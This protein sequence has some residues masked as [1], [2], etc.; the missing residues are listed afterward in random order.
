MELPYEY[1]HPRNVLDLR[2]FLGTSGGSTVR[3]KGPRSSQVAN[4][5]DWFE[6]AGAQD[7]RARQATSDYASEKALL[8]ELSRKALR[9]AQSARRLRPAPDRPS[10][11]QPVDRR[12][13]KHCPTC[14][15]SWLDKYNKNEVRA[16]APESRPTKPT[17]HHTSHKSG[18][19]VYLCFTRCFHG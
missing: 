3:M 6:A 4:S 19:H 10:T 11:A 15:H 9:R 14:A 1:Y 16:P 18:P 13:P 12:V 17:E 7:A 8:D 2:P 5:A